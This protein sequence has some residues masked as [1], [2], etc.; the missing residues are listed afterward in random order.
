MKKEFNFF[1][2]LV[3]LFLLFYFMPM[4]SLLF[5]G[6]ILSGFKLLNEYARQH[7]LTCLVPAFFIA[8]AISVFVKKDFVLRYLGS[9][10]KKH[11]SYSLASISG[12]ILTVCSCTILPL[13]AGIRKRGAG[14]GPAIAFLFSGPAINISAI[15]LTISVLGLKIG[16]ARVIAAVSLSILVG[17]S[18][19]IIFREKAE[20]GGLFTEEYKEIRIG[21]KILVIF[22]AAMVG[23]LIVN[24]LQIDKL[25]KFSLMGLLALITAGIVIFKFHR[26]TTR[27]WLKETWDFTKMLLPVLFVGVFVAGFIMPFLPQEFIEKI[28]GSNSVFGNLIASIFGA[29]MYFSTLTE[30]P[31]LQAL[32]AKGMSQGPALAL[33]LA[34]P[35]LSLPNM[36]VIR[37]VLGTKKTITYVSLV[38]FYSTIAGLIFGSLISK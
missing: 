4:D 26:Q 27:E 24:G 35:S 37:K 3:G 11:I 21:K 2:L 16:L 15:F 20:T 9:Q 38:I 6:A 22:F 29:F 17:L 5:T 14:L 32:I 34:G 30:I 25:I 19:Q 18:M 1:I 8:G 36:L 28:V 31:I 12:S 10:A 23:V 7:V 33:L 13:F